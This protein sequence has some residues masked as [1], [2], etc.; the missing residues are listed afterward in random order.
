[1][2]IPALVIDPRNRKVTQ[3]EIED[4]ADDA[5]SG[6]DDI[7]AILGASSK[8]EGNTICKFKGPIHLMSWVDC[9]RFLS[10]P[11]WRSVLNPAM[12][13]HGKTVV[14]AYDMNTGMDVGFP[15]SAAEFE[16]TI[17]WENWHQR[18][19]PMRPSKEWVDLITT[20]GG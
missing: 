16:L 14:D 3:I 1:M 10:S 15:M 20:A 13:M 9:N 11:G 5:R 19:D 12:S 8:P 4:G 18:S 6:Y 7:K 17:E 2:K